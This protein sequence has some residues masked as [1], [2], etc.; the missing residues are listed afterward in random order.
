MQ[1][2]QDNVWHSV[3]ALLMSVLI[4]TVFVASLPSTAM[5]GLSNFFEL[6]DYFYDSIMCR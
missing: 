1:S 4:K 5:S 2:I 3:A 6:C